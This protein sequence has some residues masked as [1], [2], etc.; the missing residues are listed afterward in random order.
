MLFQVLAEP[1]PY[2]CSGHLSIT[3]ANLTEGQGDGHGDDE[4][5]DGNGG[6]ADEAGRV[7][8][9]TVDKDLRPVHTNATLGSL[10]SGDVNIGQQGKPKF[11]PAAFP[12]TNSEYNSDV[13]LATLPQKEDE[14]HKE[15]YHSRHDYLIPATAIAVLNDAADSASAPL[16]PIMLI[17]R[18]AGA[19]VAQND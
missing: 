7:T 18:C 10:G 14:A 13:P 2:A 16:L 17:K 1:D 8:S 6:D 12:L 9:A 15:Q 19:P 3:F 5:G 4:D 11:A